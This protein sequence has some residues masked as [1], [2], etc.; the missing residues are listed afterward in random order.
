MKERIAVKRRFRV[1]AVFAPSR[2]RFQEIPDH[3]RVEILQGQ[4]R[5]RL[6]EAAADIS[7]QELEGVAVTG[8]G[9]F[10]DALLDS[11]VLSEES[12]HKRGERCHGWPPFT[13]SS[14]RSAIRAKSTGVAS[15][16]Q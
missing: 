15:R 9:V 4:L 11:E 16:Y 1:R 6:P 2:S 13:K 8:D 3:G 12:S 14:Q 10:A 5:R 7:T